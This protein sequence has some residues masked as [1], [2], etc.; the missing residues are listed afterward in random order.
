M[1]VRLEAIQSAK[2]FRRI[3]AILSG[4][5]DLE[6]FTPISNFKTP[7]LVT[8]MSTSSFVIG[9]LVRLTNKMDS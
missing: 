4:P 9:V 2:V 3:P 6:T 5:Q 8:I 1:S 7:D